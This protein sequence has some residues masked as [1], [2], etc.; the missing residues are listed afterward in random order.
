[1]INIRYLLK[2]KSIWWRLYR[3]R[4]WLGRY[5]VL[6]EMEFDVDDCLEDDENN[7]DAGG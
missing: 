3:L 1:V 2:V 6:A 4:R 5:L 7:E